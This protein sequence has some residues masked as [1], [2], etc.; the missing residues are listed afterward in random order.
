MAG[1]DP[2]ENHRVATPLELLF[3]L[4][5]VIG[6]GVT[7]SEFAHALADNHIWAGLAGFAFATFAVVWAWINFAWFASAYDTDDWVYRLTTMLQMVGVIILALGIAP[8]F[9]SIEHGQHVDNQVLVAGYIVMRIAMVFQWLRAARQ[10]PGRRKACLAYATAI[11]VAQIGWVGVLFVHTSVPVTFLLVI[12]MVTVEMS[13][14]FVAERRF[15]GTPWH[16]H[17]IAE[18]YSLLVIIALGEG[19]VGTVASLSAVL[20]EHGWTL[21][22]V[23][24]AVAGTGL[25]FG[26][27][28]VYFVVPTAQLLHAHRERSFRW[29]YGHIPLFG[30]I[31][32]T[33]AGLHAAAY[34]IEDQS[35]LNSVT[36]VLTVAVPVGIY[37][38]GIFGLYLILVRS[39]EAFHVVLMAGTVIVL[40]A[41]VALAGAGVTMAVCLIVVML[42]PVVTVV[43]FELIGHRHVENAISQAASEDL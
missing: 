21:D 22:A 5:F 40:G 2:H 39:F 1:R 24:V 16:A 33:G 35:K 23:L 28:W 7:A 34:F 14:P 38:L 37:I 13:G 4:T 12:V 8:M 3:D 41:A 9:R 31:V 27:W 26:M 17:H 36:T 19:V 29:G 18:R 11:T 30:A 6:F 42:A 20:N 43:G 10:D 25:T 15:R 32:A